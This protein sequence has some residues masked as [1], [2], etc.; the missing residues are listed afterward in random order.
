MNKFDILYGCSFSVDV[1]IFIHFF[2]ALPSNNNNL[3]NTKIFETDINQKKNNK[4]NR[5]RNEWRDIQ[6]GCS[7]WPWKYSFHVF[8]SCAKKASLLFVKI[9][10]KK[11]HTIFF[12]RKTF[13][14]VFIF[15]FQADY[16]EIH[17][18]STYYI[19]VQAIFLPIKW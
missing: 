7:I 6:N 3:A 5:Q 11:S 17:S 2:I 14:V 8:F 1:W 4:S 16:Y 13:M 15:I 12:S 10:E 19:H 9:H 18:E